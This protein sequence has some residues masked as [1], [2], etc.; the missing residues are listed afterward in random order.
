MNT[1]AINI[2]N[3]GDFEYTKPKF[4]YSASQDR[5]NKGFI[6]RVSGFE[7]RRLR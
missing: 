1:S 5:I 2:E 4:E 7:S 3:N 6:R